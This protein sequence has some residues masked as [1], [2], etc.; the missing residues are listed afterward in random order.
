MPF[1]QAT[2]CFLNVLKA[3][4]TSDWFG[5][6]RK[7]YETQVRDAA[8]WFSGEV[9]RLLEEKLDRPF[10][11]KIFR[12]NRDLRF[13]K[14]KTPYNTHVHMAFMEARSDKD[15][16]A[17]MVGLE[18]GKLTFGAGIMQFS[19]GRLARWRDFV[20]GEGGERVV[21]A[22]KTLEGLG[23]RV[24]EPDLKMVPPPFPQDH[25]AADLL[26]RKGL[27]VWI[28]QEDVTPALGTD[29]PHNCVDRLIV[30]APIVQLLCEIE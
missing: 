10:R 5:A 18:P 9:V 14:D 26:K 11:A 12:I 2:V 6:N 25:R 3:N 15:G 19:P 24:P 30:F 22:L 28:D 7:I 8:K 21:A 27:T 29:G 20:S 4:N 13:S 23:A 17:L 16:P 1:S